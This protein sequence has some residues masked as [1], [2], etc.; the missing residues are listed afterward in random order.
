[1]TPF[2][3]LIL[4]SPF[5]DATPPLKRHR[6]EDDGTIAA[7]TV[8]DEDEIKFLPPKEVGK[9]T[10]Q[11]LQFFP[12]MEIQQLLPLRCSIR[13][14]CRGQCPLLCRC[15]HKGRDITFSI[16]NQEQR[17]RQHNTKK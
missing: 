14:P 9:Q 1:M 2:S 16:Q 11:K 8:G 12:L 15:S 5:S 6:K 10:K 7:A 4:F 17:K 3:I 13:N